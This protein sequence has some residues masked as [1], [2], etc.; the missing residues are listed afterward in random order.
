LCCFDS[1]ENL[2]NIEILEDSKSV[3]GVIIVKRF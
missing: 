2:L 1:R 3:Q